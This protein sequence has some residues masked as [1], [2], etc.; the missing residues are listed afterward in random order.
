MRKRRMHVYGEDDLEV[1]RGDQE[2]GQ[3][4]DKET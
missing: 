2:V 1:G 4:R 3:E